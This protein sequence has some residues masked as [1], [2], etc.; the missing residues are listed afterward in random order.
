MAVNQYFINIY[1][2]KNEKKDFLEEEVA[3]TYMY[4]CYLGWFGFIITQY[5]KSP[6]LR[7]YADFLFLL[8]VYLICNNGTY[9]VKVK[10]NKLDV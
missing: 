9:L 8:N 6:K 1:K 3:Q 7:Y 2:T 10:T 4:F 5:V